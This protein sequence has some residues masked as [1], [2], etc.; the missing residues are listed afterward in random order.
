MDYISGSYTSS[1]HLGGSPVDVKVNILKDKI[2]SISLSGLSPQT[3]AMYPLLTSTVD[4][5]NRQLPNITSLEELTLDSESPY[6]NTLLKQAMQN[7][8]SKAKR[9]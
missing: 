1:I 2:T 8:L 4:K 3:E 9:E 7:A 5:I 6:M